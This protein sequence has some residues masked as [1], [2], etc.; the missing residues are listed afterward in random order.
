M[1]RAERHSTGARLNRDEEDVVY[2]QR[3][4]KLPWHARI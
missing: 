4:G 1:R 3:C 2:H